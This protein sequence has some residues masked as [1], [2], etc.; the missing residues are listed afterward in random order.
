MKTGSILNQEYTKKVRDMQKYI[1]KVHDI[2]TS[3]P[4]C[5]KDADKN[6]I[7][8]HLGNSVNSINQLAWSFGIDDED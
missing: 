3:L 5:I 7:K 8:A 2:Y 4:D 1:S 6:D